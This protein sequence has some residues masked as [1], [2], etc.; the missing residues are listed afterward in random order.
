MYLLY[1]SLPRLTPESP[2]LLLTQGKV[3]KSSQIIRQIIRTNKKEAPENLDKELEDIAKQISE[4]QILG[5]LTLFKRKRMALFT[6]LM[7]ITW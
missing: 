1:Y 5:L 4:E 3:E 2:R 7:C 6:V